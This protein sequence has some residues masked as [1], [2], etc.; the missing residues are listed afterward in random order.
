MLAVG[1][2][3]PL[4]AADHR[5]ADA[6]QA[7]TGQDP[8]LLITGTAF[9]LGLAYLVRFFGIAQ[10]A[11]D[12]AFGRISPPCRWRRGRWAAVPAGRWPRSTCR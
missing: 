4:A 8:G 2:L 6:I 5:L 10:G 3:F 7:L 11:V 12:S 1:L 9:A